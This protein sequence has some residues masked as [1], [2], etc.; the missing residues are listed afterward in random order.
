MGAHNDTSRRRVVRTTLSTEEYISISQLAKKSNVSM[1]DY[2][3]S[4]L[5]DVL[6]E[7]GIYVQCLGQEGRKSFRKAREASGASAA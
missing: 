2:I 7:E 3:R 1:N 5:I 4:V 6:D